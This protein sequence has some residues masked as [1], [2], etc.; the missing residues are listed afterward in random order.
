[1]RHPFAILIL[2]F[3]FY[4]GIANAAV[5]IL[6][7]DTLIGWMSKG[8]S[9]DFILIDVRDSTELA[10]SKIIANKS[11]YPYNFSLRSGAFASIVPE[12]PKQM[13]IICYCAGGSRSATAAEKLDSAGFSTVYSLSGGFGGW[14]GPVDTAYH[15]KPKSALPAP[16][17]LR[18]SVRQSAFP[19]G[20]LIPIVLSNRGN[21]LLINQRLAQPHTL[22]IINLD[23]KC[24]VQSENAFADR[25]TFLLP[26]YIAHGFYLVR[27]F[28]DRKARYT[29][30]GV[31]IK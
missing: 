30:I 8:S 31:T 6:P 16:S 20:R 2:A 10:A 4:S 15:I 1:M 14:S 21:L 22:Q 24:L 7:P 3:S 13:V 25:E 5:K 11:C 23:G 29:Q 19:A 28:A 9:F 12:L 26:E 18:T 17:M 27:L